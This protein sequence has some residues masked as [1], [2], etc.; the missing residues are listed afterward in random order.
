MIE[1]EYLKE[2]IIEI[3]RHITVLNDDYTRMSVDFAALKNDVEW[4]KQFFWLLIGVVIPTTI[5]SIFQLY[6]KL[7]KK[8]G[9]D[10]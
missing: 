1:F 10:N 9:K 7:I 4:L 8:N 2:T 3:N 6:E 5:A